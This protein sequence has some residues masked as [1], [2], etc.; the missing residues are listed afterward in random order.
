MLISLPRAR[1]DDAALRP[2]AHR[3]D[4]DH[5][6][7]DNV[8]VFVHGY[9]YDD[10]ACRW[11]KAR[12]LHES[13]TRDGT[14]FLD[15]TDGLFGIVILDRPRAQ[16]LV[17][18]DRYGIY[19]LFHATCDDAIVLAT[20]IDALVAATGRSE[21]DRASVAEYLL[22]GFR[23]GAKTHIQGI[24]QLRPA[25]V[26]TITDDLQLQ[27]REYWRLLPEPA[28]RT[29]DADQ[30]ARAFARHIDTGRQ[31][32]PR[33]TTPL[34][35]GLDTRTILSALLP[36]AD[37]LHCYT[38]GLRDSQ[39]ARLAQ[40]I[41]RHF[42]IEHRLYELDGPWIDGIPERLRRDAGILG[43]LVPALTFLH[44]RE[45]YERERG[46]DQVHF[47]GVL[48]NELWRAGLARLVHDCPSAD[49]VAERLAGQWVH[50]D[51]GLA[52]T[53]LGHTASTL[54]QLVV[55]SLRAELD[56]VAHLG[57]AV[58]LADVLTHRTYAAN[59]AS[60]GLRCAGRHFPVFAAF[61]QKDLLPQMMLQ[62][63]RQ[64]VEGVP[65]RRIIAAN[66]AFLTR[67]PLDSGRAVGLRPLARLTNRLLG[68]RRR[69]RNFVRKRVLG[70]RV[71]ATP[72]FHDYGKWLRT[73]HRQWVLHVCDHAQMASGELFARDA[74]ARRVADFLQ[75]DRSAEQFIF[76]VVSLEAW[77]KSIAALR[78]PADA[79]S[80]G[81]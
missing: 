12:D 9:P 34:T 54:R 51:P 49:A 1:W 28:A 66:S 6:D 73:R 37:R 21:L 75:G 78:P 56:D 23:L 20:S 71:V 11:L 27:S 69:A 36:H 5:F 42:G 55:A 53:L 60:N 44:V 38:H 33:L 30:L 46:Q 72:T 18:A 59:W 32:A 39:D 7:D 14:R 63:L 61:L 22:L 10:S 17:I 2:D 45:S 31:L 25:T 35:G 13:Y 48:G 80:I 52:D 65:Q 43:G 64:R 74:L 67:L 81:E 15:H 40:R 62:P 16:C 3:L 57:D 41:C 29:A 4:H 79:A 70:A 58:Q 76:R 68:L 19:G 24:R 8:A 50:R 77:L 26:N 47:S